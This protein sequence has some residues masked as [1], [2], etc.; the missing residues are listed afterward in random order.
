MD[1][2]ILLGRIS[3]IDINNI[4]VTSVL[5][6]NINDTTSNA[7]HYSKTYPIEAFVLMYMSFEKIYENYGFIGKPYKSDESLI[8]LYTNGL[9]SIGYDS[10]NDTIFLSDDCF[11]N[12]ESKLEN[13]MLE[14]FKN[15]SYME[16]RL[17]GLL[18]GKKFNINTKTNES[19]TR[20]NN[21]MK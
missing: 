1:K 15:K 16:C 11:Y 5:G 20:Q 10:S 13:W 4:E 6:F 7:S 19:R 2:S 21:L 8:L 17:K 18:I 3:N 12:A 9:L 14:A